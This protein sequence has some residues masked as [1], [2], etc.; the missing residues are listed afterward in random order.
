MSL[1]QYY[2]RR[3]CRV[4]FAPPSSREERKAD[5]STDAATSKATHDAIAMEGTVEEK[6]STG[7]GAKC[8]PPRP[9]FPWRSLP[10]PLPRLLRPTRPPVGDDDDE[11]VK[12]YYD[13][14]YFAR[15]GPLGP[16]WPS[17]MEP[18]FRGALY[19]TSMNLLGLSWPKIILPWTRGDWERD[20]GWAFCNAFS[21]GVNGMIEDVYRVSPSSSSD[22]DDDDDGG[23]KGTDAKTSPE[24]QS[25]GGLP[26]G[27]TAT[28]T[29][30][31]STYRSILSR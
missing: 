17:P 9:I 5:A 7:L 6:I 29:T 31:T 16:G 14:E 19:L 11:S 21:N 8:L 12:G 1:S 2:R 4:G 22:D 23:G 27:T 20:V 28:R 24:Q 30:W 18:W 15:G 13:S 25:G 10:D 26:E 3:R